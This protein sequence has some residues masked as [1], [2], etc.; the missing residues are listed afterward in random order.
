MSGRNN[1]EAPLDLAPK[2]YRL[3]ITV[4]NARIWRQMEMRGIETLAELA[5]VSGISYSR[6]MKLGDLKTSQLKIDGEYKIGVVE[7]A[8]FFNVMPADLWSRQMLETPLRKTRVHI[9]FSEDELQALT[10][11]SEDPETLIMTD[12]R[13]AL[14]HQALRL[15]PDRQRD[16]LESRFGLNGPVETLQSIG[17]RYGVTKTTIA[18]IEA[19]ALRRLSRRVGRQSLRDMNYEAANKRRQ[20]AWDR[21]NG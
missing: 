9:D 3:K 8:Q 2:D 14:A 11:K 17:D 6:I 19:A 16:I 1:L 21:A 12:Q 20:E 4:Q 15:L 13:A 18:F 7:L 5:R 10:A